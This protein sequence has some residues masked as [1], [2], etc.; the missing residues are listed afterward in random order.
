RRDVVVEPQLGQQT[1]DMTVLPDFINPIVWHWSALRF[2]PKRIITACQ[3]CF[4]GVTI[5]KWSK[6]NLGIDRFGHFAGLT[7][8]CPIDQETVWPAHYNLGLCKL[9]RQ[10]IQ[11]IEVGHESAAS[12]PDYSNTADAPTAN[13]QS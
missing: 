9:R 4:A 10:V 12:A 8:A 2:L 1:N 5:P 7:G 3:S 11:H 6:S 13:V